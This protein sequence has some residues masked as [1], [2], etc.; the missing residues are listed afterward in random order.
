[1]VYA[2]VS[3]QNAATR[4]SSAVGAMRALISP[5]ISWNGSMSVSRAENVVATMML[6]V[7]RTNARMSRSGEPTANPMPSSTI[8]PIRGETSIA[9][10][11]TA[12]LLSTSPSVAIP[13][14][15][16]SWIQ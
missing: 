15:R 6:S 7:T 5:V 4:R 10:I 9:P 16:D 2:A 8:G 13:A 14:E 11:T 1:V 12:V 3:A